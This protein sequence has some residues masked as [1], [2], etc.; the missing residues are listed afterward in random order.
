M[1]DI[2]DLLIREYDEPGKPDTL[3]SAPD[4]GEPATTQCMGCNRWRC[5]EHRSFS[6]Y[7]DEYFCD[8]D[9]E[10]DMKFWE[11]RCAP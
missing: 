8:V 7:A 3:C 6:S 1:S 9:M 2:D 4:C 11:T 10:Y 5:D